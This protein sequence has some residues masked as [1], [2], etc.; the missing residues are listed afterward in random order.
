MGT[1]VR[2]PSGHLTSDPYRASPG[3]APDAGPGRTF[4]EPAFFRP[5]S[6]VP[7]RNSVALGSHHDADEIGG[8]ARAELLHD[9]GTVI[10]DGA[11]AD[12]EVASGFLVGRARRE[13]LQ[14]LAFAPRQGF[15][16]GKME[17]CDAG[18]GILCPPPRIGPDCLLQPGNDFAAPERLFDEVQRAVFDRADR[19]GDI[20]LP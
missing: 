17:R 19:H 2:D 6:S 8:I 18:C 4:C 11:R 5:A 16:P 3:I 7:D 20:A 1:P 14:H 10:F 9:V 13:L 12:P 15:T